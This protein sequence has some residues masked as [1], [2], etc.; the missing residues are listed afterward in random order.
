MALWLLQL[1]LKGAWVM[2]VFSADKPD[3]SRLPCDICLLLAAIVRP[4]SIAASMVYPWQRLPVCA[5][6]RPWVALLPHSTIQYG[7]SRVL[8]RA[9][10]HQ[11][12]PIRR[13]PF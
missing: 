13:L 5:L 2:A 9:R 10:H 12:L 4:I 3:G 11:L 8:T 7:R 1:I 6:R